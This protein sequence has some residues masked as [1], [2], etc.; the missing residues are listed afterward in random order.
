MLY[1]RNY[2]SIVNQLYFN[3]TLKN[4][5]KKKKKASNGQP[6]HICFAEENLPIFRRGQM[7]HCQNSGLSNKNNFLSLLFVR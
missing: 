3:K 7:Q 6:V 2:H 1:S 5:K 4:E